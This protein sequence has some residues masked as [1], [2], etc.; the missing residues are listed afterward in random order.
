[1]LE[2]LVSKVASHLLQVQLILTV[3]VIFNKMILDTDLVNTET[4][5]QVEIQLGSC[6]P[7]VR[8]FSSADQ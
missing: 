1:M 6:Q 2:S 3:V 7:L 8:V 5:F 4:L